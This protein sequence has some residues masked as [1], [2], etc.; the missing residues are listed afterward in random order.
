M[1][2]KRVMM[3]DGIQGLFRLFRVMW[4]RGAVG[5]GVGYS[6]K[7]SVALMPKL[8][9]WAREGRGSWFLTL[10]GI[11]L[12]YDRSY[13]GIFGCLMIALAI[14][15][16]LPAGSIAFAQDA[17][18]APSAGI[19]ALLAEPLA[20]IL[21][22]V[23]TVALGW[24][25]PRVAKW[26]GQEQANKLQAALQAAGDRAAGMAV[27]KLSGRA[28]STTSPLPAAE[29]KIAV[30]A[31]VAYLKETMPDTIAKLGAG[32]EALR[33]IVEANLGLKIAAAKQ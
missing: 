20:L 9:G 29:A 6:A 1:R 16:L 17:V 7:L 5:D 28:F 15:L 8:F 21:G 27:L 12:H 26:L 24:L 3:Y 18:A 10:F 30:D 23:V 19:W 25:T 22:A 4:E 32:D 14:G 13:A 33:K 11:R 31:G 2:F